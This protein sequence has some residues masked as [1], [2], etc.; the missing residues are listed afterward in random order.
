MYL[1]VHL[2]K[3]SSDMEEWISIGNSE[4]ILKV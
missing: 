1:V 3:I 2:Y 4:N